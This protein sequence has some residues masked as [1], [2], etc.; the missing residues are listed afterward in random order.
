M[1]SEL[2]IE[3]VAVIE[4][5]SVE[6][7]RG[8]N[9]FTGETGAGKSIVIDSIN[10]VLGQRTSK[11]IVRHGTKKA[12]VTASFVNLNNNVLK[13]LS[14]MGIELEEDSL[15]ITR[16]I[17]ADAKSNARINGKPVSIGMLKEIGGELVNIHGQH[18]N[19]ILLAPER[20][21]EILDNYGEYSDLLEEYFE[22]YKNVVRIKREM[23][24]TSMNEDEKARQIDLLTYQITEIEQ[25]DLKEGE[26][27][28]LAVRREEYRNAKKIIS[29]LEEA[30][31]SLYGG[32]MT[33]G[34]VDRCETA[35]KSTEKAA[36]YYEG[37][38]EVCQKLDSL[39]EDLRAVTERISEVIEGFDV[40]QNTVNQIEERLEDIRKLKRKYGETIPDIYEF[41][42]N[43]KSELKGLNLSEEHLNELSELG[44]KEYKRLLIMCEEISKKRKFA[45]EQ[46]INTVT[47]ELNFLD[48][49][50]VKVDVDIQRIKPNSKGF[51]GIE[52]LIS[53]NKGEPPKPIAK[54]ASGGELSRI[55]LAIKNTLAE[56]DQISTLIFDE[57]DAG[58]SGHA[59]QKIGLKLKQAA[60]IRQILSVTHSAQIAALADSHYLIKKEVVGERT[61]TNVAKLEYDGRVNEVAR[62]MSTDKITDLMLK[63]AKAM[64]DEGNK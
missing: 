32:D 7:T 30:Y 12:L 24:K 52:F 45:A 14:S 20:H 15:V 13:K 33:E 23:N 27:E 35:K 58:V 11:E 40:N 4:K 39:T 3:N 54:I 44:E 62:I 19:Q 31:V 10:A 63:N 59:V 57:I 48:M 41:L 46:F 36:M 42:E 49:P 2:Y 34:A 18:D 43:A 9:V 8:L 21:I 56:K 28:E 61:Y 53:T 38:E 22:C 17:F 50:N 25:A 60:K 55:M 5:T 37:V 6:F 51:D 26:D 64:I 1:L 29:A 47:E 16:E